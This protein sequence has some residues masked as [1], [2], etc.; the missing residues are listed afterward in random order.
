[1]TM[2]NEK[3]FYLD[4]IMGSLPYFQAEFKKVGVT[5]TALYRLSSYNLKLTD[6]IAKLGGKVK[7]KKCKNEQEILSAIKHNYEA[8]RSESNKTGRFKLKVD[9]GLTYII[10]EME[11]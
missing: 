6:S 7:T 4:R 11:V 1:M 5:D 2:I 8:V 3:K 9:L 10:P